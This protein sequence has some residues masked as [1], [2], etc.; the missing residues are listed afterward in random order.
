L[1]V[2]ARQGGCALSA[3]EGVV[4]PDGQQ[5]ANLSV[6]GSLFP[7][8]IGANPRFGLRHRQPPG[9]R[10]GLRRTG[11]PWRW[12]DMLARLQHH[13]PSWPGPVPG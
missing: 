6:H 2:S 11:A 13:H 8:S 5:I 7:T 10:P 1:R 3:G 9:A 4:R 12:A